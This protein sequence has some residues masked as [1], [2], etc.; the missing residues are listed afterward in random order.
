M[1]RTPTPAQLR[2]WRKNIKK[3]QRVWDKLHY[4]R[5]E[6]NI[7]KVLASGTSIY[8]YYTHS[9]NRNLILSKAE[10]IRKAGYKARVT[11]L[12]VGGRRIYILYK[13]GRRKH[14]W[15]G[16]GKREKPGLGRGR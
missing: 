1:K 7:P 9:S 8:K 5:A 14:R 4:S 3:A 16:Y 6:G 15:T 11:W 10:K 13:G 2:A 12:N